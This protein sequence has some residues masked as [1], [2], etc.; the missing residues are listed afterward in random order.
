MSLDLIMVI[1]FEL[2]A[3]TFR[4]QNEEYHET[5]NM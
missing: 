1:H 3:A 5:V 4:A 2:Q